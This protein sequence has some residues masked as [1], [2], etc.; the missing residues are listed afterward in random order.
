MRSRLTLPPSIQ[1]LVLLQQPGSGR[2]APTKPDLLACSD[3][4]EYA[5]PRPTG[6]DMWQHWNLGKRPV[7]G[8]VVDEG[9]WWEKY[10]L[11]FQTP[12]RDLQEIATLEDGVWTVRI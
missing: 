3:A 11:P 5:P 9:P 6:A 2:Q 12:I 8:D 7:V 4:L 1:I 10:G